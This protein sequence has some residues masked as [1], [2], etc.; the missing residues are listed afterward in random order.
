MSKEEKLASIKEILIIILLL[1]AVI[2]AFL[3]LLDW[4][5]IIDFIPGVG[6]GSG[7]GFLPDF[8]GLR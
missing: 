8:F 2:F 1:F 6:E 7:V 3:L 4:F 5:K